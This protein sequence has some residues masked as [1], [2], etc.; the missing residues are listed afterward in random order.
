MLWLRWPVNCVSTGDNYTNSLTLLIYLT[1]SGGLTGRFA[2]HGLARELEPVCVVDQAV[3]DR[4]SVG[5]IP[6]YSMMPQTLI[7]ESL[8][9]PSWIRTTRFLAVA[10]R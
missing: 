7:G 9:R 6:E 3:H 4:V 8:T 5:R 10:F 1:R 2:A